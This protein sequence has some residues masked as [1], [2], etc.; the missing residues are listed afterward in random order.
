M[1]SQRAAEVGG[2]VVVKSAP[3]KGTQVMIEVPG[4]EEV[5]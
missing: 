5:G 1:M 2:R 4:N 3:G